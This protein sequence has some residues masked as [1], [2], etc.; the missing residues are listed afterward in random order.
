MILQ[1]PPS[2]AQA[3]WQ[4]ILTRITEVLDRAL[5]RGQDVRL[6][7][8]ERLTKASAGKV[9]VDYTVNDTGT[10]LTPY[11]GTAYSKVDAA[12]SLTIAA[13][14]HYT[15]TGSAST[16]TLPALSTSAGWFIWIKNRGSGNLTVQRAGS[17]QVYDTAAANSI[18][19][20]AGGSRRL[21]N[22][23]TYWLA[24]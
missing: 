4:A 17:D 16:W 1:A 13:P 10:G 12:A 6:I 2:Y 7:N 14:G 19:V 23:A 15:F 9:E 3:A 8:S 21:F 20:A 22:D 24:E 5:V 11:A 18:T